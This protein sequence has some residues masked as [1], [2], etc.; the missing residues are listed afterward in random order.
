[1][2][3]IEEEIRLL[4]K[5]DK[6][7]V[8]EAVDKLKTEKALIENNI[9]AKRIKWGKGKGK[10]FGICVGEHERKSRYQQ[11]GRKIS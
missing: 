4:M 1:M 3:K 7:E 2:K 5:I 10:I 6:E 11:I 8:Q 9:K